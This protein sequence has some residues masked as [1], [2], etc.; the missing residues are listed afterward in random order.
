MPDVNIQQ[1]SPDHSP[2]A[3]LSATNG[4]AEAVSGAHN[5]KGSP[6]H[7]QFVSLSAN[8]GRTI[9]SVRSAENLMAIRPRR[10][11][12]PRRQRS[13]DDCT[14]R[15]N[16]SSSASVDH[17]LSLPESELL[18]QFTAVTS[19]PRS[20]PPIPAEGQERQPHQQEEEEQH[21]FTSSLSIG[22]NSSDASLLSCHGSS[23]ASLPVLPASCA[24]LSVASV[25]APSD[26][27]GAGGESVTPSA[28][29]APA[30]TTS[31]SK[32][33]RRQPWYSMLKQSYKQRCDEFRRLFEVPAD[34][35]LLVDYSCA[36]VDVGKMI[37]HGR[38][39]VSQNF[40]CFVS[41]VIV[42]NKMSFCVP[43]AQVC[44]I[45]KINVLLFPSGV[46]LET[47]TGDRYVL[48]SFASRDRAFHT[49]DNIWRHC[50]EQRALEPPQLWQMVHELYGS[51]LGLTSEDDDYVV[52]AAASGLGAGAAS[53]LS[54]DSAASAGDTSGASTGGWRRRR[55]RAHNTSSAPSATTSTAAAA[56]SAG[57]PAGGVDGGGQRDSDSVSRAG[58][59]VNGDRY[60]RTHRP[61][62]PTPVGSAD[63]ADNT[64]TL[65]RATNGFSDLAAKPPLANGQVE[66]DSDE[67]A[68][69]D[70][71]ADKPCDGSG[72]VGRLV[73]SLELAMHV[74]QVFTL[75]F[76]NSDFS[77]A[78]NAERKYYDVSA[79]EWHDV[80]P[81][82][83]DGAL[84]TRTVRF[85]ID[86]NHPLGK[87]TT[88]TE[89][90]RMCVGCKPGRRYQ[91]D[92]EVN[93]TGV[94]MADVFSLLK[95]YC[96]SSVGGRGGGGG[97]G[98]HSTRLQI[99]CRVHFRKSTL[100]RG[101]IERTANDG[102]D[103]HHAQLNRLL[104][105]TAGEGS[106]GANITTGPTSS[107]PNKT[108]R[109]HK[110]RG[111]NTVGSS[112]S[113]AAA[114]KSVPLAESAP[115]GV[116]SGASA[117]PSRGNVG[118]NSPVDRWL[119]LLAVCAVL[120]LVVINLHMYWRLAQL[121]ALTERLSGLTSA[122]DGE[123]VLSADGE[124]LRL[125]RRQ[126]E[127][128]LTQWRGVTSAVTCLLKQ[129]EAVLTQLHQSLHTQQGGNRGAHT[130]TNTAGSESTSNP[131]CHSS[132]PLSDGLH[133]PVEGV[134]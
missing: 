2:E 8:N 106:A 102:M 128:Q 84:K 117:A 1:A 125:I 19:S 82:N 20:E 121:S 51:E 23:S 16:N 85:Q 65:T 48:S 100:F 57:A 80:S 74:D 72:H 47:H 77:A 4:G 86:V 27:G 21:S 55:A 112:C 62:S 50:V 70:V 3:V 11:N 96:L 127:I 101:F 33:H 103:E 64:A 40:V 111:H 17:D 75:L 31:S 104:V 29:T 123:P 41:N 95:H 76:T 46:N 14:G 30:S 66:L 109:V 13:T 53:S 88:V 98:A 43:L 7:R 18:A 39:Y 81:E 37:Y 134:C 94:P 25:D 122:S 110:R 24:N 56:G 114:G 129:T 9:P 32:R 45:T 120:L 5:G 113:D 61:V 38:L 87:T 108:K 131:P 116:A 60:G 126:H 6:V 71:A 130:D 36:Q 12:S 92:A 34:E 99:W 44:S 10:S 54:M 119:S 67:S 97:R 107:G 26:S 63:S 124:W 79:E 133:A 68:G 69:G 93:N 15:S 49:L 42:W 35:R 83:A 52:P 59:C 132:L 58:K 115:L 90:Q 105:Q 73:T 89:L 28:S 22:V 91:V 78:F 118:V